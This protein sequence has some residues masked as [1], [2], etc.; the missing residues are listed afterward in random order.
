MLI[1][2]I[3]GKFQKTFSSK[4]WFLFKRE[5]TFIKLRKRLLN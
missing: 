1:Q 2:Y 3:I 4:I 5:G